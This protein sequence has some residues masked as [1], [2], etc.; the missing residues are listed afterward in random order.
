MFASTVEY[1][2]AVSF[3][4]IFTPRSERCKA[5]ADD[6][7]TV[8]DVYFR[9]ESLSSMLATFHECEISVVLP[10]KFGKVSEDWFPTV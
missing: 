9:W 8:C 4:Y 1:P 10:R 2:C 5:W 6:Y 7:G 3:D